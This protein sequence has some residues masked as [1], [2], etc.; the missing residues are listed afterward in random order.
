MRHRFHVRRCPHLFR[1]LYS[2]LRQYDDEPWVYRRVIRHYNSMMYFPRLR[3]SDF[4][5]H[6]L[7]GKGRSLLW[8]GRVEQAKR[9]FLRGLRVNPALPNAHMWLFV[10]YRVEGKHEEAALSLERGLQSESHDFSYVFN[11]HRDLCE[12]GWYE[13]AERV[14]AFMD[15]L[16]EKWSEER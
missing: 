14:Q 12:L 6:L 10:V 4:L 1:N 2:A 15:G 7:W 9:C 8:L 11:Y 16:V 3:D 13:E 5:Y